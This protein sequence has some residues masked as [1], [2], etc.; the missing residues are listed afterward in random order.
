MDWHFRIH[1]RMTE[2]E[3]RGQHRSWYVD[4]LDWIK[5]RELED[6]PSS[7]NGVSGSTQVTSA[8]KTPKE[9]YIAVPDDPVLAN[10]V[11]PICQEKFEMKWLDDAQEFVWMDACMVAGRVFHASC[12]AEA[13]RDGATPERSLGKRKAEDGLGGE[14]VRIKTEPV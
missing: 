14:R 4:E 7:T 8:V 9:Q 2:A 3:K 1:Q 10:S 13:R 11:C 12:H 6:D 5:S